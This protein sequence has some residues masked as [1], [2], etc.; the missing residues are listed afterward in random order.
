M[1]PLEMKVP[2]PCRSRRMPAGN[3]QNVTGNGIGLQIDG[4]G[5]GERRCAENLALHRPAERHG[6]EGQSERQILAGAVER[7]R[8]GHCP[9]RPVFRYW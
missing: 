5:I 9:A 8:A 7:G 3:Q 4:A 2:P 6:F 1:P